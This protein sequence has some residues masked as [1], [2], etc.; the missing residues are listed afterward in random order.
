MRLNDKTLLLLLA[1]MTLWAGPAAAQVTLEKSYDFSLSATRIDSADYKYFLMDVGNSQ[2]RI[3]NLDHTLW[4]TIAIPLPANYYLYDIKFVTRH[5]FNR[6]DAMELWYSA[7][8]YTTLETGRYTSG[9]ISEEG[10]VVA[11]MPGGLYAY[12]VQT[13]EN[14]YKLTVYAYDYSVSP[15]KVQTLVYALPASITAV[16]HVTALLPDPWPN[17]ASGEIFL[18]LPPGEKG[19]LLQVFSASGQLMLETRSSGEAVFRLSTAG[20]KPGSYAYRTLT[21][22]TPSVTKRFL[23]R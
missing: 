2:C 16:A 20:W 17:P 21:G 7:Y 22:Q 13:G 23:V 10:T 9:I 6:D 4:K 19:A 18:P 8:E 12:V 15:V 14:E 3:Y 1:L 11:D 5:L